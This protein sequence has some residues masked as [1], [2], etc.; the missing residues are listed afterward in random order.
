MGKTAYPKKASV[1]PYSAQSS[2]SKAPPL[3][4]GYIYTSPNTIRSMKAMAEYAKRMK[5]STEPIGAIR[6]ARTPVKPRNVGFRESLNY[7][8]H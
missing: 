5:F 4:K 3:P 6:Q 7:A 1:N 2:P 8:L